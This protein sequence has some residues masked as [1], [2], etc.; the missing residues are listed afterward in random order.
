MRGPWVQCVPVLFV[1]LSLANTGL[2]GRQGTTS[3]VRGTSWPAILRQ[4]RV[5]KWSQP[6]ALS[7]GPE[8]FRALTTAGWKVKHCPVDWILSWSAFLTSPS[9]FILAPCLA[10]D[11]DVCLSGLRSFGLRPSCLANPSDITLLHRFPESMRA[12][13]GWSC[14]NIGRNY[15]YSQ[16]ETSS[17]DEMMGRAFSGCLLVCRDTV[18]PGPG[19]SRFPTARSLGSSL[20]HPNLC[21]Y[22]K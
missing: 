20:C 15:L 6:L 21:S 22:W 4:S 7:H 8:M 3:L 10:V 16:S 5:C 11:T 9:T 17:I 1:T 19:L 2:W 14:T 13:H 12:P 18:F